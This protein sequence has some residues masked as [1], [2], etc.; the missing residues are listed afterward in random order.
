MLLDGT[1]WKCRP[2]Q[3]ED[4]PAIEAIRARAG[5]ELS[6]HA[7]PSLYLWQKNMGLSLYLQ[8]DFFSVKIDSRGDNVWFFPCG[9]EESVRNFIQSGMDTPN[10]SLCYLRPCDAEWL[11]K[12]FPDMWEVSREESSD[13]YI[14][15]ISDYLSMEGGKYSELRKKTRHLERMYQAETKE[16]SEATLGDA[17][18]VLK[19][20]RRIQHH[21]GDKDVEDTDVSEIALQNREALSLVGSILYLD[22][23]PIALYAGFPLDSET[24]DVL[25][26]KCVPEAP[27]Y[28][29]Y[30]AMREFLRQHQ[31]S[32]LYC[33]LE[34]DLGIPG[35]RMVKQK[36]RPMMKHEIWN[37][38]RK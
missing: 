8:Q 15:K 33:N 16:I 31:G 34:E 17:Y 5:H 19:Q 3:L 30:L 4:R 18:E 20:W 11:L 9:N 24:I 21:V 36:M 13:E 12:Q 37:A 29:V 38:R 2:V 25:I 26:G 22:G 27:N 23:K 6:A 35:I 1:Q 14:C 32:Y 10:F 28:T 7:F